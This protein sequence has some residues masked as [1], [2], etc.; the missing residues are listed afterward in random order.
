[1]LPKDENEM[2]AAQPFFAENKKLLA[3]PIPTA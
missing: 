1:M 2:P 3:R